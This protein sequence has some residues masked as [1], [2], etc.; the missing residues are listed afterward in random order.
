MARLKRPE[1]GPGPHKDLNEAIHDLHGRAGLPSTR[2]LAKAVGERVASKSRIHDAFSS[3]RLPTWG[4]LELLVEALVSKIPGGHA[5][6]EQRRFHRLWLA[7]AGQEASAAPSQQEPL[8]G[9]PAQSPAHAA[10]ST[11]ALLLVRVEWLD[12]TAMDINH[13]RWLRK[14]VDQ[15]LEDIG[16]PP[17]GLHRRDRTAGSLLFIESPDEPAGLLAAT[18]LASLDSAMEHD[19]GD[20]GR[21]SRHDAPRPCLRFLAHLGPATL[22][23]L[24]YEGRAITELHRYWDLGPWRNP[25]AGA[26]EVAAIVSDE[27][28][29]PAFFP[30]PRREEW[31]APLQWSKHWVPLPEGDGE[32]SV[33]LTVRDDAP[34]R[35]PWADVHHEAS[36]T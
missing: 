19:W 27:V 22:N 29:E 2:D 7:A 6:E 16:H 33:C 25:F 3:A 20:S 13:R 17:E 15:A 31:R 9:E 34:M 23:G 4:L 24:N 12:P 8:P 21:F 5:G 10:A 26:G 35:D 32:E 14:Y 30:E 1:L 28:Y 11:I 36:T 18:L